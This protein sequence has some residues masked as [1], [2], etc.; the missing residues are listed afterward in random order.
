VNNGK[1]KGR[2]C[3]ELGHLCFWRCLRLVVTGVPVNKRH[4]PALV[5]E[6]K[7]LVPAFLALRFKSSEQ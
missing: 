5:L 7:F 3:Y 1:K 2:G 4:A 6:A